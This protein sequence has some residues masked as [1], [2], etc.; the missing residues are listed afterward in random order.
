[1]RTEQGLLGRV[2]NRLMEKAK[3][4]G[5]EEF[6]HWKR[7]LPHQKKARVGKHLR[8]RIDFS[9]D[10]VGEGRIGPDKARDY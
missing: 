8:V 10:Q 3:N 9:L 1:M 6:A 5:Q 4:S 7:S 2:F